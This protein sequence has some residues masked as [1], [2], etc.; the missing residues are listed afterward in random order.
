MIPTMTMVITMM[1]MVIT[2]VTMV[3][4]M[5][6]MVKMTIKLSRGLKPLPRARLSAAALYSFPPSLPL[7]PPFPAR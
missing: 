7:Q 4:T 2:M 6:T 3:I 1:T 5:M